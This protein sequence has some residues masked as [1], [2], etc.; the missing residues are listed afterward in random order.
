MQSDILY[1]I[2]K[3]PGA[4]WAII[5]NFDGVHLGHQALIK[6]MVDG[7]RRE[8]NTSVIITFSPHPKVLLENIQ[9]SYY[10][11]T[12]EEKFVISQQLG[13]DQ[14]LN[15]SFSDS[16]KDL[17]AEEFIRI[18]KDRIGLS[19]LVVGQDFSI[20][21]S[22]QGNVENLKDIFINL[23]I[24]VIRQPPICYE[25]VWI[26]SGMIRQLINEGKISYANKHLGRYYSISGLVT[27][28]KGI[29]SKFG[30]PTA[31]IDFDRMKVLP[32]RG[33]YATWAEVRGK[34]YPAV[35]N[36]GIRPTF[37]INGQPSIETL[38]LDFDDNIYKEFLNVNFVERI[39]DEKKFESL[40]LLSEQI[41]NDKESSRRILIHGKETTDLPLES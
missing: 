33:V 39:R 12:N 18:L 5:G 8:G 17:S 21:K 6:E 22:R 25:G 15:L 4:S 13:A 20:G 1:E 16:L 27:E 34:V 38:L 7:A 32:K 11:T 31:N 28:G 40:Q 2:P 36:V 9:E 26:S 10:L 3:I 35:T 14:Y 41:A 29:G 23:G 19:V 24:K 37:E 30:F